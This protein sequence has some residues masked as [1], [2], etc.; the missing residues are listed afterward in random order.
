MIAGAMLSMPM[1]L[2]GTGTRARMVCFAY[3]SSSSGVVPRRPYFVGHDT[4][5]Q[6]ASATIAFHMR[7]VFNAASSVPRRVL[8]SIT[9]LVRCADSHAR[10]SL[11]NC[12][13]SGGYEKSTFS[14]TTSFD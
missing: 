11:R 8:L 3:T 2:S 5:A 13:A 14:S 10:S 4:A 6:P 7:S 9:S 12:S 1:M